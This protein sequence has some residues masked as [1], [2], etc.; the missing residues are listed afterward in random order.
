MAVSSLKEQFERLS[1]AVSDDIITSSP[2]HSS[3]NNKTKSK[4]QSKHQGSPSLVSK[5]QLKQIGKTVSAQSPNESRKLK[6][7]PPPATSQKPRSKSVEENNAVIPQVAPKPSCKG[8]NSSLTKSA[9]AR[10]TKSESVDQSSSS[11]NE[12]N[13]TGEP[14]NCSPNGTPLRRRTGSAKER[15]AKGLSA[16]LPLI[17]STKPQSHHHLPDSTAVNKR[18]PPLN[19]KPA[20][21]PKPKMLQ[22]RKTATNDSSSTKTIDSKPFEKND[23]SFPK[24][25]P[26]NF[27]KKENSPEQKNVII[28][29][30]SSDNE[31]NPFSSSESIELHTNATVMP[32]NE[33][34]RNTFD[35]G[36]QEEYTVGDELNKQKEDDSTDKVIYIVH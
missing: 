6:P 12:S 14:L 32:L 20:V 33:Y 13:S 23:D 19:P 29:T 34:K 5:K 18:P 21:A 3:S 7:L 16:P 4:E 15:E 1:V 2:T 35:S 27:P 36:Y 25:K 8:S 28:V 17:T 30:G 9:E 22:K 26:K 11:R 10:I 24:M 31:N